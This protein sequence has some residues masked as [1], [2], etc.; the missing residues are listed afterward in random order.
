MRGWILNFRL[1][2]KLSKPRH[3]SKKYENL[4][5]CIGRAV[6]VISSP[7]VRSPWYLYS[8]W[9]GPSDHELHNHEKLRKKIKTVPKL[10]EHLSKISPFIL[11]RQLHNSQSF[12][13]S[14]C[15]EMIYYV[16]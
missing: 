2:D 9:Q 10:R 4:G 14:H 16:T 12:Q 3:K 8:S 7:G 6:R 1:E 11:R 5:R 13:N 15:L